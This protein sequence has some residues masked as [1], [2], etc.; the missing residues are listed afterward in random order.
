MGGQVDCVVFFTAW[1]VI[2]VIIVCANL[3][4]IYT[5]NS[6]KK[7]GK[8]ERKGNNINWC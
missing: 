8:T 3:P 4:E 5:V 2:I 1:H 7:K 6:E